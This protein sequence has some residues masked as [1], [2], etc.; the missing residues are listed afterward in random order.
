MRVYILSTY[1]ET[2]TKTTRASTSVEGADTALAIL[3]EHH[4]YSSHDLEEMRRQ[5]WDA[6]KSR[7]TF[8][9]GIDLTEAY[10]GIQLHIVE[11][12]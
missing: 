6:L 9:N 3:A 4:Q 10:G 12:D 5:L 8:P 2:G 11:L 1:D 7:E